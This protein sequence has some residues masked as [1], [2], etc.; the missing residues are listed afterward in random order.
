MK[1]KL[2]PRNH[3]VDFIEEK[4]NLPC[5]MFLS[6]QIMKNASWIKR[7]QVHSVSSKFIHSNLRLLIFS[8]QVILIQEEETIN[9]L[10]ASRISS[11][12][13]SI[14]MLK[15]RTTR[16]HSFILS[17]LTRKIP[18]VK[19]WT[20]H[21]WLIQ[22]V[23]RAVTRRNTSLPRSPLNIKHSPSKI[24]LKV[25]TMEQLCQIQAL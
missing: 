21:E 14:T 17:S 7:R 11:S 16:S 4:K 13:I 23:S 9:H 3:R 20:V 2:I 10:E 15:I 25:V 6:H 1:A 24:L 8:P 18:E 12:T 19:L 5:L 22:W